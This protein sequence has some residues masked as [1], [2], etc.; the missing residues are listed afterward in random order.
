MSARLLQ[1]HVVLDLIQLKPNL[2]VLVDVS[3][4]FVL[5]AS[6]FVVHLFHFLTVIHL[7]H[8]LRHDLGDENDIALRTLN[9][10]QKAN[11]IMRTFQGVDPVAMTRLYRSFCIVIWFG[12]LELVL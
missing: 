4:L 5:I 8:T 3:L 11:C 6:S 12:T 9:M 10:I 1:F 7:G 2:F